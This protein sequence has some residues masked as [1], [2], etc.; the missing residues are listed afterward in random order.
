VSF[1]SQPQ[2]PHA[3][4]AYP[5]QPPYPVQP[6]AYPAAAYPA[7]AYADPAA[8]YPAQQFDPAQA[9]LGHPAV[10]SAQL[11]VVACRMCGSVPAVPVKF[12]GHQGF[13]VIMRFLSMDGPFC[14]DCGLATFRRM[15][16]R[17]LAQGWYGYLSFL[18]TPITVLINLA[19]RGR[20]ASLPAP[21]PNPYAPSRPPMD[22]GPPLLA[23]PLTWVG[24]VIMFLLLL[25]LIL[26]VS[27]S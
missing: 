24:L 17:T 8:G 12:R 9:Y 16:S 22:P 5:A 1:V 19:R 27:T 11:A 13:V 18:I 23:R 7:P 26:V 20:V 21:H 10:Q 4:P 3:A 14:R 6:P 15:T 2:P 25:F